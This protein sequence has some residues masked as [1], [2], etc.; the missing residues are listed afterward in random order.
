M[1]N[2]WY[3]ESYWSHSGG[4]VSGPEKVV[5][6]TIDALKEEGIDFCINQDE[7]KNNFLF[8]YQHEIA[9]KKHEQ[10]EHES[11]L[12]GPQVWP[13]DN[14]GNFLKENTDFYKKII[15]PSNWVR[16]LFV[17]KLGFP[18][19]K[20][21]VWAAP[22]KTPEVVDDIS[23]D[24]LIYYKN[25]P[26]EHLEKVK[27][28]LSTKGLTFNELRYGNYSQDEFKN[29]LSKVRFCIIIDSTE[30]QGIAIQEMMSLG[31]PLLVWDVKLWDYM[32]QDY[33]VP[34][35]SVPY[36]SEHCGEKIYSFNEMEFTFDKF[37][38]KIDTYDSKRLFDEE[39]SYNVSV[40]K[41]LSLFG[42]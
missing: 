14:Y 39:L 42:E 38:D 28:F 2:L 29:N 40:K 7:Y 37:Y 32:G 15:T 6:G 35:T 25:R 34:S 27:S 23:I 20:V 19:E 21:A 31:K 5:K 13:F 26:L 41:L 3:E 30:S 9:H 17:N 1:I 24:C 36:W 33:I 11:C 22:I 12:I 8:Q 16:D 18:S 10:L 4:R